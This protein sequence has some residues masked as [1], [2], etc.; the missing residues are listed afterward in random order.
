MVG[1]RSFS[2]EAYTG[3][4]CGAKG[5]ANV[6]MSSESPMKNRTAESPRFPSQ[7]FSRTGQS[8]LRRVP[9]LQGVARCTSREIF[10]YRMKDLAGGD[11]IG[12]LKRWF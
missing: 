4:W 1:E 8:N 3:K 10:G 9:A 6:G 5:S 2:S 7:R 11:A 12:N